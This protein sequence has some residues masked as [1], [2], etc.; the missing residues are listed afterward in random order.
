MNNKKDTGL[1]DKNGQAILEGSTVKFANGSIDVVKY[2]TW[3]MHPDWFSESLLT[4]IGF[5]M[6]KKNEPFGPCINGDGSL[7]EVLENE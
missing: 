7:Y 5:Y 1:V 6:E 3:T 4:G 2:G